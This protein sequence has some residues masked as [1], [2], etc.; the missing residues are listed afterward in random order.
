MPSTLS[1]ILPKR[2]ERAP[3]ELLPAMP[4]MVQRVAVEG[5]TGKNQPSA[6]TRVF[7]PFQHHAG[8]DG[9]RSGLRVVGDDPVEMARAIDHEAAPDGLAVLGGAAA[10]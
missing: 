8:L 3:Q 9:D 6:F 4:P 7:N 2:R 1:L 10:A 5:S